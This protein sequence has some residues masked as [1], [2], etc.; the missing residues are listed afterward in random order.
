MMVSTLIGM[1]MLKPTTIDEL[2]FMVGSFAADVWGGRFEETWLPAAGGTMQGVGRH[3]VEG[4]VV[5]MEFMSIEPDATG[6]LTMY[7]VLGAPSKGD[8][9]PSPFVLK[10]VV[11]S[12]AVFINESNDFPREIHYWPGETGGLECE[13]IGTRNG[14]PANETFHFARVKP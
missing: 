14:K 6:R 10:G 8:K 7:M 2:K 13:L 12:K 5:F 4:K 1:A 9:K 3:I 11:G